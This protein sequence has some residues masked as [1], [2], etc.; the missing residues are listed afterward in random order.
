V[1]HVPNLYSAVHGIVN[2]VKSQGNMIKDFILHSSVLDIKKNIN[3]I[4]SHSEGFNGELTQLEISLIQSGIEAQT[5]L[6][7]TK[8]LF[9]ILKLSSPDKLEE[10]KYEIEI[11]KTLNKSSCNFVKLESEIFYLGDE[12]GVLYKYFHGRSLTKNSI[13]PKTLSQIAQ[14][15][16]EMHK[17]LKNFKPTTKERK[18]FSI[19][20]F[21]FIDAFDSNYSQEVKKL[22]EKAKGE[23]VEKLLP[24]N[25]HQFFQSVIHEDLELVNILKNKNGQLIF[26][27]FGESHKSQIISDVSTALKELILNPLGMRK[28]LFVLYLQEYQKHNPV[29]DQIQLEVVPLLM[30]RRTLFMFLY[31]LYK[32]GTVSN[33]KNEGYS[34]NVD[35]EKKRLKELLQNRDL[36]FNIN[37]IDYHERKESRANIR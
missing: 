25:K 17:I 6:I 21:S 2:I 24:Y 27:D 20:D 8:K 26:I 30:L 22:I 35:I 7:K 28:D 31:L 15:Q 9:Y 13:T 37:D 29:L 14:M 5:F 16:A 34:C 10:A 12:I 3:Y 18:R 36:R 33:E 11:L 4:L 32:G 1:Q 23:L 19:F